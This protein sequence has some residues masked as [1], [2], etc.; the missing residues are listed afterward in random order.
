MYHRMTTHT[1]VVL[2]V[3]AI[4]VLTSYCTPTKEDIQNV[5]KDIFNN[6]DRRIKPRRNLQDI[7][8]MKF[9]FSL[10]SIT[11][12][13]EKS[14]MFTVYGFF[15]TRWKDEYLQW[16]SS[17][18]GGVKNITTYQ[19]NVWRPE[20]SA[21]NTM[22]R[23]NLIGDPALP[24]I[25]NND[26]TVRWFAG[27][28]FSV[29]CKLHI[30]YYPFD[31]QECSL[32]VGVWG[33]G[34]EDITFGT[35]DD[36][37]MFEFYEPHVEWEVMD[38]LLTIDNWGDTPLLRVNFFLRRMPDF[39]VLTFLVPIILL[40]FLNLSVFIT[41]VGEGKIGF[42]MTVYLTFAVFLGS[43]SSR[44]PPNSHETSILTVYL[45]ALAVLCTCIVLISAIQT[46][47]YIRYKDRPIPSSLRF[48]AKRH[49]WFCL[50][51]CRRKDKYLLNEN[52]V[53]NEDSNTIKPDGKDSDFDNLKITWDDVMNGL[54][55][56]LFWLFISVVV[57]LTS[58]CFLTLFLS[59]Q[60]TFK[61]F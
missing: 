59:S 55:S 15:E 49:S 45:T 7:V 17:D 41:P 6:Y 47:V 21:L 36:K 50:S 12:I 43:L 44:L 26:G 52:S 58:S 22:I 13:K 61:Y 18:Y 40:S 28:H 39:T 8:N 2:I 46:R 35:L 9:T 34:V 33:Y 32:I 1:T 19:N 16:N 14:Q 57:T 37:V 5:Y 23:L 31:K 48:L 42:S 10:V 53:S 54:D 29:L 3:I 25:I 20:I 56:R 30:K 27:E 51:C 38:T 4:N 24:V 60:N 11:E